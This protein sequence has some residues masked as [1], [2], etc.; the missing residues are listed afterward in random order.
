MVLGLHAP[1]RVLRDRLVVLYF[2]ALA[3]TEGSGVEVAGGDKDESPAGVDGGAA[4]PDG[5]SGVFSAESVVVWK[6]VGLPEDV[7]GFWAEPGEAAAEG[8]ALTDVEF[9]FKG[10]CTHI[11]AS[12]K[13]NFF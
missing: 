13:I 4:A 5:G 9:F 11:K 3:N 6:H 8:A 1:V 2:L 10:G 12:E 7:S